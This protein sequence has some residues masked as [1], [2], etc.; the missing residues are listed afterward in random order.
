MDVSLQ[1]E[2]TD[3]KA[4]VPDEAL[5]TINELNVLLKLAYA[6]ALRYDNYLSRQLVSFQA[7]K[8]KPRYRWYKF[9][10][11]YSASLVEYL[12]K[13]YGIAKGPILDPFCRNG[14]E[15]FCFQR[16]RSQFNR[17]LMALISLLTVEWYLRKQNGLM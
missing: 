9:K 6:Y 17:N 12:F 4:L 3:T 7:N 13:S 1:I 16:P 5:Q 14:H 15:P 8:A 10:E 2:T 11:A